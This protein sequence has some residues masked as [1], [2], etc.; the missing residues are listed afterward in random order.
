M[1]HKTK[2]KILISSAVAVALSAVARS[3]SRYDNAPT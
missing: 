3:A 1:N 2:T